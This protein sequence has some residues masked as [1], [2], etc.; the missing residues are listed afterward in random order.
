MGCYDTVVFQ[1]PKCEKTFSVQTKAGRCTLS[2]FHQGAVPIEIASN[3]TGEIVHCEHCS[4]E[5]RI[6]YPE[7]VPTNVRL[8]LEEVL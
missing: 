8:T 1:C 6:V 5:L 4:T 7:Y 3:L 2:D